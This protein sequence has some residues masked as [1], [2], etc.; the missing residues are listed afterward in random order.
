MPYM[1]WKSVRRGGFYDAGMIEQA[2]LRDAK[3]L[4]REL[5]KMH[6]RDVDF[7]A[8]ETGQL[9]GKLVFANFLPDGG[10]EVMIRKEQY[11]YAVYIGGEIKAHSDQGG[12]AVYD[13]ASEVAGT[14]VLALPRGRREED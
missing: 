11:V 1:V 6:A 2:T 5:C 3:A 10:G 8:V 13:K 14:D 9:P 4:I 7:I 12:R